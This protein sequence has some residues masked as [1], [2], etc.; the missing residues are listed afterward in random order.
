LQDTGHWGLVHG[1]FLLL[2]CSLSTMMDRKDSTI[3]SLPWCFETSETVNKSI[4]PSFKLFS[5]IFCIEFLEAWYVL[6]SCCHSY[7]ES[8][9]NAACHRNNQISCW[10]W[11]TIMNCPQTVF[12]SDAFLKAFAIKYNQKYLSSKRFMEKTLKSTGFWCF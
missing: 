8:R 10:C 5:Q 11:V 12:Y 1:S 6:V 2:F 4:F 7:L 9:E 3:P